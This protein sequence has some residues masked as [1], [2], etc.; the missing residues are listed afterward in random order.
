MSFNASPTNFTELLV[1]CVALVAMFMLMRKRYDSNLPLLFY[2]L[3]VVFTNAADRQINPAILY[4]GLAFCLLLRFEFMGSS[5]S[6][7]VAFMASTGLGL[8]VCAMMSDIL[9]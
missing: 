2:F 5:I 1:V 7:L 6:K 8:M 9:A 4:G 3:A